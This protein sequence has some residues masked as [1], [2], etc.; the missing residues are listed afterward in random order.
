[1]TPTYAALAA[2]AITF[3]A[4]AGPA[5]AAPKFIEQQQS[6]EWAAYRLV[7]T[8][9]LNVQ[10]DRIGKVSEVLLDGNGQATT[11]VIGVGGTLG[12][13]EKTVAVPYSAIK[14]G[15][16]VQSRRVVILDA[17]VDALKG[18]PAFKVA[19]P[20]SAD[21]LKQRASEWYKIAKDKVS[22]YS[23]AASDK[24]KELASP[25]EPVPA[26]PKQ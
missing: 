9:V 17:S 11:V 4:I 14:I 15:D 16:V 1:M 2:A 8:D 18:A 20:G 25:K 5:S 3:A 21:R 6:G 19:D 23:K 24:A 13:P 10:A 12:I 7:G 22:E 26:A